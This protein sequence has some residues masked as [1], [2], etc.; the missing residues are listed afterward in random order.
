MKK[1]VW[2]KNSTWSCFIAPHRRHLPANIAPYWKWEL[3]DTSIGTH[4]PGWTVEWF[5]EWQL[6]HYVFLKAE[7][8]LNT[9]NV[10]LNEKYSLRYELKCMVFHILSAYDSKCYQL[11]LEPEATLKNWSAAGVYKHIDLCVSKPSECEQCTCDSSGIA[12]CLVA[13]CAP[14][15]CVNPVYQPGK[16]CPECKEGENPRQF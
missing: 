16:C 12:R 9:I 8:L 10:K 2:T 15:P 6:A 3:L 4:S 1:K 11:P 5:K 7:R 14:P 13:D